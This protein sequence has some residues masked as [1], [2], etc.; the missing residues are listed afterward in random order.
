[1]T[2]DREQPELDARWEGLARF[3]AGQSTPEEERDIRAQ[4]ASDP[5]RAALVNALDAALP[6]PDET[7]LSPREVDAA[8]ASVMARRELVPDRAAGASPDVLPFAPRPSA[9]LRTL[10][11]RWRSAGVR[12]AA[13]VLFV[14]GLSLLWRANQP[15]RSTSPDGRIVAAS[16]IHRTQAGQVDTV[17]LGDGSTVVLGPASRLTVGAD[18]GG[19]AR[20][21]DFEGQAYFDVV[22][23]DTRPFVV[24]TSSATLRDIGT[25]FSVRSDSVGGTRVA[26]TS[27]AVDVVATRAPASTPTVLHA[28]DRAEVSGERMR[29]ER[30][31]V[32]EAELSWT[33][34]VLEFHDATLAAVA[35][36][37]RRWYGVEL[38]VTDSTIASRRLTATFDRASADDVGRVLAAVLGGAVTRTGDTLRLRAAG[39]R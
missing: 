29:V 31:V 6:R 3:L 22:H 28:G 25:T 23:D 32:T 38:I 21:L 34:G 1:M 16:Q 36:E 15:D 5:E 2:D 39:A 9:Q 30:G 7:S 18:F 26:V 13:A 14:A 10:R 17:K 8:L 4:V 35:Q 11:S 33:R 24:R 19:K 20:E 27:G 37:L 12:A